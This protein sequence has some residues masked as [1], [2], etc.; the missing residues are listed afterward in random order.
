MRWTVGILI[1]VLGGCTG[2]ET[3]GV[4]VTA[5]WRFRSVTSSADQGCP[6]GV[7]VVM[8]VKGGKCGGGECLFDNL[9]CTDGTG[10]SGRLEPASY[11][12]SLEFFN[13]DATTFTTTTEETLDLTLGDRTY[14]RQIL[15]DGG[16]FKVGWTLRD[17]GGAEHTC[18]DAGVFDINVTASPDADPATANNDELDCDGGFGYTFGYA[19]GSYSLNLEAVNDSGQTMGLAEPLTGKVIVAPNGVTDLGIVD[20]FLASP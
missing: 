11:D 13:A 15:L 12:V 19:A 5:N 7:T 20:I 17:S 1:A 18:E 9:T 10:V 14:S 8:H 6:E 16:M 3:G 4:F 2:D